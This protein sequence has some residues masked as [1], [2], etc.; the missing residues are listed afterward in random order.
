MKFSVD[1]KAHDLKAGFQHEMEAE[2][3]EAALAVSASQVWLTFRLDRC[4]EY[5]SSRKS[6][7]K[8]LRQQRLRLRAERSAREFIRNHMQ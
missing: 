6:G 5:W 2:T 1:T 3:M 8:C 4:P 7:I